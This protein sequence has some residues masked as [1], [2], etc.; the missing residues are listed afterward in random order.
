M[1]NKKF[2]LI[3]GASRGIGRGIAEAMAAEGFELYLLC[4]KNPDLMNDLPGQH[5]S[6]DIGDHAFVRS[7]FEKI[8]RLDV[9]VNNAGI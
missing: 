8:P 3:T 6:G 7:V 2:A 1:K 9:L 4:N 5:F